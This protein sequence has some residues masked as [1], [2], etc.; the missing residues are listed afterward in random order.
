[1]AEKSGNDTRDPQLRSKDSDPSSRQSD[2]PMFCYDAKPDPSQ[3]IDFASRPMMDEANKLYVCHLCDFRTAFRN[4]LLNHQAVHSDSRPWVCAMCD[5]AAKRK[6]DLKKHLHTIHGMMVDSTMLKPV[7]VETKQP[8]STRVESSEENNSSDSSKV[9]SRLAEVDG[10]TFLPQLGAEG[11]TGLHLPGHAHVAPGFVKQEMLSPPG[12]SHFLPRTTSESDDKTVE[13]ED[14]PEDD[15][16]ISFSSATGPAGGGD[17]QPS[18]DEHPSHSQMYPGPGMAPGKF[19]EEKPFKH[20]H[21]P[22]ISPNFSNMP[23][24]SPQIQSSRSLYNPDFNPISQHLYGGQSRK[25]NHFR[26]NTSHLPEAVGPN[27]TGGAGQ[28]RLAP[29]MPKRA[30]SPEKEDNSC[31]SSAGSTQTKSSQTQTAF[32]CEHCNIMFFQR[33]MYL[34]HMGL[35]SSENPWQCTVCGVQF[36]EVY[37]FTSH[38]INQ[39]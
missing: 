23:M 17:S 15:L 26:D 1:M 8:S 14:S 37:S 28:V 39:H 20:G 3:G 38:F 6:Q 30:R 22:V 4:S 29:P 34:M 21:G 2:I 12:T 24:S 18:D 11:M 7:D 33:A 35:H 9:N 32:L 27:N 31:S 36:T 25:R 19:F 5:Y 13:L 10:A 16:P